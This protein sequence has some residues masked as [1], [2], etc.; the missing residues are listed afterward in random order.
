MFWDKKKR[1]VKA[2]GQKKMCWSICVLCMLF[3]MYIKRQWFHQ[4]NIQATN[5]DGTCF[6]LLVL[7]YKWC[8]N[9]LSH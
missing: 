3:H 4:A 8:S 5:I 6:P 7:K 1:C 9:S 2:R